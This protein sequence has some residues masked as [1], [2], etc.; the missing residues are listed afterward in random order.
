MARDG[1]GTPL[2]RTPVPASPATPAIMQAIARVRATCLAPM[3]V[4]QLHHFLV[5]EGGEF[6][7][8]KL[9]RVKKASSKLKR[10]DLAVNRSG[11]AEEALKKEPAVV[12]RKGKAQSGETPIADP[13]D[14]ENGGED[15]QKARLTGAPR[16][17]WYNSFSLTEIDFDAI[18]S[19]ITA[20]M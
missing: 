6:A 9:S 16:S 14:K 15:G 3:T 8:A 11:G 7:K 20:T 4:R 18:K 2:P 12:K 1:N 10:Q 19:S 13:E 17:S 5:T